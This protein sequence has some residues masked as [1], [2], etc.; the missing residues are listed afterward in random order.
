M[1]LVFFVSF[2]KHV[3]YVII[4]K[5]INFYRV[6]NINNW[7]IIII[8]VSTYNIMNIVYLNYGYITSKYHGI[9]VV[10]YAI[11][12]YIY[13]IQHLIIH[14]IKCKIYATSGMQYHRSYILGQY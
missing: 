9:I 12:P 3:Y 7:I 1:S 8:N 11:L 14:H 4:G 5:V 10:Y 13:N 6:D 2:L